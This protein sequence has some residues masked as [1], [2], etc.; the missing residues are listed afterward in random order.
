MD[1]AHRVASVAQHLGLFLRQLPALAF[2]AVGTLVGATAAHQK[3]WLLAVGNVGFKGAMCQVFKTL[4]HAVRLGCA[5]LVHTLKKRSSQIP[6]PTLQCLRT[7]TA[8]FSFPLEMSS[9]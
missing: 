6:K 8:I 5:E 4:Q 2:G 1:I 9:M 3:L 7:D